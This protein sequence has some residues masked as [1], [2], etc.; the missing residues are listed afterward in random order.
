[1]QYFPCNVATLSRSCVFGRILFTEHSKK[2]IPCELFYILVVISCMGLHLG[3]LLRGKYNPTRRKQHLLRDQQYDM[4][5]CPL[6]LQKENRLC[7]IMLQPFF[8]TS[9]LSLYMLDN[10]IE[11][12]NRGWLFECRIALSIR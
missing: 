11:S 12:Q 1:M 4:A 7:R 9:L 2:F 6:P 8:Q 3:F 10:D 5:H